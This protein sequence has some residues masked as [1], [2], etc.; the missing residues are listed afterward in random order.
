MSAKTTQDGHQ[1]RRQE[2]RQALLHAA[3]K[4]FIKQGKKASIDA[5]T[6]TA[7]VAKGSFY[8]H[9]ESR[10]ALFDYV[11]ESRLLL[12]MQ[13][14]RE[15]QPKGDHPVEKALAR[16]R[17]VFSTLLADPDSCWLLLHAGPAERGGPIDRA[18][19]PVIQEEFE[20]GIA[21]GS[22]RKIDPDLLYAAHFGFVTET[23]G[24]LLRLEPPLP[25]EQAA[26]QIT[27]L[28]FSLLGLPYTPPN[29][30]D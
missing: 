2:T 21:E 29:T 11:L 13:Q 26:E 9:F 23:I 6:S 22:L 25:P 12:L 16:S 14:Y 24:Y 27:Q 7:G 1:R 30:L 3:E 10:D 18:L 8:N 19:R 17:F 20:D 28:C 5:I 4:L 15:F